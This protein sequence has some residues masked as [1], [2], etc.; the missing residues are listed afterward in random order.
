M[1]RTI[2]KLRNRLTLN[3]GL[4][5]DFRNVPTETDNKLFWFDRSN[6]LGGLCYADKDLGTQTIPGLGGPI[7]PPGNGFYELLRTQQ[8]CSRLRRSHLRLALDSPIA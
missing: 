5:W 1:F 3:L 2:G 8:S 7:A 6:P 4:R